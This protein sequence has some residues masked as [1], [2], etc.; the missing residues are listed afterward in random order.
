MRLEINQKL[1]E[2]PLSDSDVLSTELTLEMLM[3]HLYPLSTDG[4]AVALKDQ[5]ISRADWNLTVL[6]END[7]LLILTATQG[8]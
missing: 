6:Q 8:G 5:V 4:I 2:Y 3:A 7:Q 1:F